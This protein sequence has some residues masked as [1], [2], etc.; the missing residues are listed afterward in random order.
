MT[1][2]DWSN[3]LNDATQNIEI[4]ANNSQ[5]AIFNFRA[6]TPIENGKQKVT[7]LA[8]GDGTRLKKLFRSNRTAKK[9]SKHNAKLFRGDATFDVDFPAN[10]FAKTRKSGN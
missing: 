4:A 5:N 2:N 7:A 3:L 1:E 9:L 8:K 6:V 10:S